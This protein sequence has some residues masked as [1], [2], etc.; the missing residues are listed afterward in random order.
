MKETVF[1]LPFK[2]RRAFAIFGYHVN[3]KTIKVSPDG[4]REKMNGGA[5]LI[6]CNFITQ[7]KA[8]DSGGSALS[9][10]LHNKCHR[11]TRF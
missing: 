7:V 1:P 3:L 11:E 6:Y 9:A 2:Y 8:Q 4:I 10:Y 5:P